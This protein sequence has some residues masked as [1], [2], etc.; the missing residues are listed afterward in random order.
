MPITN[1][2]CSEL[3]PESESSS[4]ETKPELEPEPMPADVV[5]SSLPGE[6]WLKV[7]RLLT[8]RELCQAGLV[9]K[10]LLDLTRD[11]S[12]WT[13]VRLVGDEAG[14]DTVSTLFRQVTR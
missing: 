5:I 1:L 11:P 14:T 8:R 2:Q 7:L 9:C 6:M 3:E 12:L 13:E 4:S 10:K